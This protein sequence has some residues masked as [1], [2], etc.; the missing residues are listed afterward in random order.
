[1][2]NQLDDDQHHLYHDQH[3]HYHNQHHPYHDHHDYHHGHGCDVQ[4]WWSLEQQGWRLRVLKCHGYH[5][6]LKK[7]WRTQHFAISS[8]FLR[9][10]GT[11]VLYYGYELTQFDIEC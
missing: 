2:G 1:M 10:I 6:R 5:G 11:A 4:T 8:F 3:H 9:K 7:F